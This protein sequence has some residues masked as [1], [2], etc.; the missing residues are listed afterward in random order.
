MQAAHVGVVRAA[1]FL[2]RPR[3]SEGL[4]PQPV[5]G[6]SRWTVA[7]VDYRYS[8][9]PSLIYH[10]QGAN[11]GPISLRPIPS[12]SL[13][14]RGLSL[15]WLSMPCVPHGLSLGPAP[16]GLFL[17][18]LPCRRL[19]RPS[20]LSCSHVEHGAKAGGYISPRSLHSETMQPSVRETVMDMMVDGVA[21]GSSR[22]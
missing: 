22:R 11:R 3:R 4:A 17:T 7:D 13:D 2:V 9:P 16:Q 19:L 18:P 14:P 6:Y 5:C 20:G 21:K 1:P 12:L 15:S 8:G 10:S